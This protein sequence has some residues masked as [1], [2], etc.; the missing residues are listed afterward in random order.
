MEGSIKAMDD[1]LRCSRRFRLKSEARICFKKL[2]KFGGLNV[3]LSG[4]RG[5]WRVS[6]RIL[7]A[8]FAG[9][10]SWEAKRDLKRLR[11]EFGLNG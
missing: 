1:K 8:D 5:E 4:C 6:C 3:R 7:A 10:C 2:K 11:T 9:F